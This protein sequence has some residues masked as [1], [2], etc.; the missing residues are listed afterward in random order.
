MVPHLKA[1]KQKS[2][3][4]DV[5]TLLTSQISYEQD[6]VRLSD[7]VSRQMSAMTNAGLL[8]KANVVRSAL[9]SPLEV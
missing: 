2:A 7:M 9:V 3:D 8:P 1:T 6:I 4:S 5:Q